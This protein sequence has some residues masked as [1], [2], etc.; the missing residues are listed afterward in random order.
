[1]MA[2]GGTD[3]GIGSWVGHGEVAWAKPASLAEGT[4]PVSEKLWR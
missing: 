4:G 1:M 2:I 3:C